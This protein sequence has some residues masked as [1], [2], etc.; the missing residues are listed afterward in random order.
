ML[1]V[2]STM[3]N[4]IRYTIPC[5]GYQLNTPG[6]GTKSATNS[7]SS[8]SVVCYLTMPKDLTAR[9][10]IHVRAACKNTS[11]SD[12]SVVFMIATAAA[13]FSSGTVMQTMPNLSA[14]SSG[15]AD[16]PVGESS[17][18]AHANLVSAATG[19]GAGFRLWAR[20][21]GDGTGTITMRGIQ[22]WVE[23]MP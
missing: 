15:N 4:R 20:T 1:C 21:S 12:A 23:K 2:E 9:D 5:G 6:S 13:S 17:A 10:K 18:L 3:T 19:D 22:V 14:L 16:Y 7:Q 8:G 11:G